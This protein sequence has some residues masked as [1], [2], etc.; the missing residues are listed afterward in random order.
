MLRARRH[1]RAGSSSTGG[2]GG[3][4][5]SAVRHSLSK[6]DLAQVVAAT[7]GYSASDLTALC[8]EAALGP[9][10]ELGAA[11]ASVSLDRIRPLRLDDFADALQVRQLVVVGVCVRGTVARVAACVARVL[12]S[13]VAQRF[14]LDHCRAGHPAQPECGAAQGV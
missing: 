5:G 13:A 6:A 12:T 4:G 1:A 8:R 11:I 7:S 9:V 10:R 3:G 2:G 14:A